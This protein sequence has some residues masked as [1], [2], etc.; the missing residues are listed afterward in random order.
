[1]GLKKLYL[2]IYEQ[3]AK[4]YDTV[5]GYNFQEDHRGSTSPKMGTFTDRIK[6]WTLDRPKRLRMIK[7]ERDRQQQE[8]IAIKQRTKSTPQPPQA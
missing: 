3:F 4:K 5:K 1:M 7:Q 6:W 2:D 8:I